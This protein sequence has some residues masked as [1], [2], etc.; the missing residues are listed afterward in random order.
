M[1][2]LLISFSTDL[3]DNFYSGTLHNQECPFFIVREAL[4]F[5]LPG[6]LVKPP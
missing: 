5:P 6:G 1:L 4:F 2:V 3:Q